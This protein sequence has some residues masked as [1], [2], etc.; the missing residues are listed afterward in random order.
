MKHVVSAFAAAFVLA[1]SPC[2]VSQSPTATPPPAALPQHPIAMPS[3]REEDAYAIY[4]QLLPHGLIE[5]ADAKR[6][7]WLVEG[8]TVAT[9][10]ADKPCDPAQATDSLPFGGNPHK[11]IHAP[12]ERAL[13]FR[14]LLADF[15]A[16]CHERIELSGDELRTN[17]PVHM[18]DEA[19]RKR[20]EAS[21]FGVKKATEQDAGNVNEFAGAAGIH[22]FSQ[23]YFTPDHS[24]AM[25]FTGMWCGGL[26]GM[27]RWV[28]LEHK[29]DPWKPVPWV[30]SYTIS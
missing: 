30:T 11:D 22:S 19:T 18:A 28:V 24:L 3:D 15:D 14:A 13:E 12:E 9:V 2:A 26:C 29:D 23:V 25:V 1:A 16:H 5:W 20:F 17:L 4:A 10:P 27:W 21:P 6:T 8:T 7:F